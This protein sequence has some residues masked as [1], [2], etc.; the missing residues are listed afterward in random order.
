MTIEIVKAGLLTTVQDNGRYGFQKVGVSVSGAMDTDALQVAN[1]LVGNDPTEAALEI[2]L[3]GPVIRFHEDVLF[4]ITGGNLS[5]LI[6]GGE[7]PIHRPVLAVK[8]DI[9]SFGKV[10]S[11]CRSYLAFAGGLEMKKIMNSYSTYLR[12]EIG[13]YKGRVLQAGDKLTV[14]SYQERS[15]RLSELIT[16]MGGKWLLWGLGVSMLKSNTPIIRI[17][18][19]RHYD[20]FSEDSQRTFLNSTYKVALESDRMGYRLNGEKL[21]LRKTEQLLSE[22]VSFGTIQVPGGGLPIILMADSQT[23]GGYPIIGQVIAVDRSKL[24]QLKP[25]D[26]IVF[27]ET[28]IMEAE[29]LYRKNNQN[30]EQ[31]RASIDARLLEGRMYGAN[32]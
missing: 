5:P 6:N 7:I 15:L 8:G 9:L 22:P 27:Q 4:A 12:A 3:I 17:V 32:S 10:K 16:K 1:L 19:G 25:G 26:S 13:G 2:T 24:A 30:L 18:R 28:D 14:K 31:L 29:R 21:A 11:G 23:V 20:L